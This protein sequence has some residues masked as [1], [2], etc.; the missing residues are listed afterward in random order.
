LSDKVQFRSLFLFFGCVS[1]SLPCTTTI[2]KLL[3]KQFKTLIKTHKR[4][5]SKKQSLIKKGNEKETWYWWVTNSSCCKGNY[6]FFCWII[7][8]SVSIWLFINAQYKQFPSFC[9]SFLEMVL[10]DQYRILGENVARLKTDLMKEQLA[11]FRSQL[12]EFAR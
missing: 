12:E 11:T 10:K 1:L 9:F 6:C 5:Q 4:Y 8:S 7:D 2:K 3:G